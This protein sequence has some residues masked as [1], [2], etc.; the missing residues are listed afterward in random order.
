MSAGAW[1]PEQRWGCNGKGVC[2]LHCQHV[3]FFNVPLNRVACRE[4]NEALKREA[5]K[6]KEERAAVRQQLALNREEIADREHQLA[7][8]AEETQAAQSAL[9]SQ[10]STLEG[11]LRKARG[12]AQAEAKR[13]YTEAEKSAAELRSLREEKEEKLRTIIQVQ[14]WGPGQLLHDGKEEKTWIGCVLCGV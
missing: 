8:A 4:E 5:L 6:L 1:V 14:L 12:A 3:L 10:V 7:T 11:E 13:L 9:S 2:I